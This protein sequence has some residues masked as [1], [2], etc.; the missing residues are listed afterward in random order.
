MDYTHK[1]KYQGYFKFSIT[2]LKM[3]TP[4]FIYKY[5]LYTVLRVRC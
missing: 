4:I 5:V 1:H 2:L 3:S